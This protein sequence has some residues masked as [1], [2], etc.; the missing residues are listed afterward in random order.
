MIFHNLMLLAFVF[1][2]LLDIRAAALIVLIILAARLPRQRNGR[3]D[4]G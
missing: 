3:S 2:V 1:L 4:D